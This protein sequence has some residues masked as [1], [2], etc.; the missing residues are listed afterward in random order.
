MF[1]KLFIRMVIDG[2]TF[3]EHC[4][5]E[6]IPQMEYYKIKLDTTNKCSVK[7]SE[8]YEHCSYNYRTQD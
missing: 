2:V 8:V 5:I 6:N 3:L 4:Y 7:R 1:F